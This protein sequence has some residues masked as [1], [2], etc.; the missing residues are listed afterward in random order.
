[1]F[2]LYSFVIVPIQKYCCCG[3]CG[4]A[5]ATSTS[6]YSTS[7]YSLLFSS[8]SF[9]SSSPFFH[10]QHL[11]SSTFHKSS[12]L[13]PLPYIHLSSLRLLELSRSQFHVSG[14]YFSDPE[15][16]KNNKNN[17]IRSHLDI[18]LNS[19]GSSQLFI[20]LLLSSVTCY[21][22][23]VSTDTTVSNLISVRS[24]QLILTL[25]LPVE[26]PSGDSPVLR[27]HFFHP[28][29]ALHLLC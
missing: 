12:S 15:K 5:L 29:L 16:T 11:F 28:V 20:S 6:V 22:S 18:S 14:D 4:S 26:L 3:A 13:C 17:N 27:F 24:S 1:M 19:W 9:A 2:V 25:H 10:Q 7:T 21:S 23:S 8:S